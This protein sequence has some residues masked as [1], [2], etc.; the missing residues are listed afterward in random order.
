LRDISGSL[1]LDTKIYRTQLNGAPFDGILG[2][3]FFRSHR[4]V[5][6]LKNNKLYVAGN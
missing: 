2:A 3:P 5:F 6:D 4:V 1:N